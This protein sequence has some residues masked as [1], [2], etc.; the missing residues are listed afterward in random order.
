MAMNVELKT[1]LQ[2][3]E[4]G[5]NDEQIGKLEAAGLKEA[6]DFALLSGTQIAE[7][8]SVGVITALKIGQAFAPT[9]VFTAPAAATSDSDDHPMTPP[10][11]AEVNN[12][13]G[14]LGMSSDVL[15]MV[16][17]GNL[18]G[19]GTNGMDF[20]G[21]IPYGP[22]L[23]SY[24]PR[25]KDIAYQVLASLERQLGT[26][27]IVINSDG[28]INRELTAQYIE[29]LEQGYDS[30]PDNIYT[31][32]NGEL[33]EIVRVGVDAQSIADADPL[34]STKALQQNGQGIGRIQW[35]GVSLDVRQTVYFA[36]K[37]GEVGPAN[38]SS[39]VWLRDNVK[40]GMNRLI[41]SRQAPKAI[42]MFNE[43]SRTGNLPTLRVMLG[44]GP[45]KQ[46]VTNRRRFTTPKDLSGIGRNNPF[47]EDDRL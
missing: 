47:N 21:L 44:R 23:L 45:R 22:L 28:S 17:M 19:G 31:D 4:F 20:S 10:S 37:T 43:A 38:E 46:E 9:P 3:E 6:T 2:S 13:A 1:R 18:A 5:L 40:P 42:A 16:L 35:G 8:A 39:L 11:K 7:I 36:V 26:D 33:H 24:N 12:F 25:R 27:I 14:S 41:L 32:R 15:M 30:A 29:S 34:D